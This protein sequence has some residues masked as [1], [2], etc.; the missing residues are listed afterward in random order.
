LSEDGSVDPLTVANFKPD[1]APINPRLM[2]LYIGVSDRRT[3]IHNCLNA[4][5]LKNGRANIDMP[6]FRNSELRD[7]CWKPANDVCAD[8]NDWCAPQSPYRFMV[9]VQK[10]L[11]VAGAVSGV[12]GALLSTYEKGDAEYLST[13]RTMH[14]RQMLNLAL[15]IRQNQW[16][17]ADWQVQALHKTK[18]IAITRRIITLSL[19]QTV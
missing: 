19:S 16:R 6:Y 8:E 14:E 4:R 18:E 3:L 9:Q 10:A 7:C 17:E 1:C 13:M 2:C 12:G 15:E 5:R 11:E